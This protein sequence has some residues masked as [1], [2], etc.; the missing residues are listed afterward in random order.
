MKM[1]MKMMVTVIL[2]YVSQHAS[3]V[4]LYEGTDF[5]LL[6]CQFPAFSLLEPSVVWS[7][8]DLR[9][10]TVHQRQLDGDQLKDQNQRYSGRTSMRTDALE[11]GDLSLTLREP[12]TRDSSTYTCSL[13]EGGLEV[14][15]GEVPLQVKEPPDWSWILVA[16]LVLLVLLVLLAVVVVVC[17]TLRKEKKNM[18]APPPLWP[19]TLT[20]VLFLLTSVTV[21]G[22]S[23]YQGMKST[24]ERLRQSRMSHK[25]FLSDLLKSR[26]PLLVAVKVLTAVLVLLVVVVLSVVMDNEIKS[27]EVSQHGDTVEVYGGRESVLLPCEDSRVPLDPTVTWSRDDLSLSTVHQ[28]HE[29]GDDLRD[30]NQVYSSRTSMRTDALTTGDLSLTLRKLHLSDSGNYTCTITAFGNERRLRDIQLQV[31]EPFS[32]LVEFWVLLVL[33]VV[34][35]GVIM[36]LQGLMRR[37]IITSQQVEVEV[38]SGAESVQL[39]FVTT[40]DLSGDVRVEWM[41]RDNMKVHVYQNGSDRPEDQD[42]VYRD[43]TEMKEDLLRTGDLSLTLKHL[44][45]RDRGGYTCRVYKDGNFLREKRVFLRVKGQQV[46]VEEEESVQLPFVTTAD[47]SGDVRVEW[48]DSDDRKVHVNQNGSDR[49]EDQ[50]QVYRDRTE[51]K[52]DLLRTGDLSLTLKHLTVRDTRRYT[53]IVYKD[54]NLLRWKTVTLKVKGKQVEVESGAES[55]QLPFKT[56]PHLSGDVRVEW[57]DRD[58]RRVHVNQNGSDRPEDQDQVYRDRT[59][60]KEDLLRTGDLSLTLK[61]LRV[62]DTG[63]YTCGVYKDGNLLRGKTVT[64]KVKGKQVEVEEEE[65]ESV[66]LPFKTTPHLSGDVRVEWGNSYRKVHVYQNG[67]DRPEDQ[68]QVYRD[69]TEMKEDLLRT[70]DLSLTL[71]HLRVRDT[72]GY[73]CRVYKDGNLIRGKRVTLKVKERRQDRNRSSSIDPTPLMADQSV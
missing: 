21:C 28:R 32:G 57:T 54:G 1:K 34:S 73:T 4:E 62:R 40:A 22:V 51:M 52:E 25:K 30:Q 68:D 56:T 26:G 19:W 9:P 18:E 13:R 71:K 70:G 36:V 14:S 67:S 5:V 58:N 38:E 15:R 50:D 63:R 12:T 53:C 39:P 47:L 60:M 37:F 11:T 31:K 42:Q 24:E 46:E 35:C 3:A 2:L 65:E 29:R 55:V 43:R 69:R 41:D 44:R 16:V 17:V 27:K 7:R 72:G 45:V 49:P 59:E 66:Q 33:L 64:L 6:A 23:V 61:H 20:A 10:S 48:I 8:S